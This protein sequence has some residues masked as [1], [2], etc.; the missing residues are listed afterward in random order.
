MTPLYPG[1]VL[2]VGLVSGSLIGG[3]L[4]LFGAPLWVLALAVIVMV[5]I[6]W[7]WAS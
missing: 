1:R 4:M 5:A 3:L 2:A 6:S 7:R